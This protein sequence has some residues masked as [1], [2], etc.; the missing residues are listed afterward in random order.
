MI[1]FQGL[2]DNAIVPKPLEEYYEQVSDTVDDVR[3]FYRLFEIPGLGHCGGGRSGLPIHLFDDLK[4][5]VENGI[6]PESS[7]VTITNLEGR[8]EERIICPYPEKPEL[9][10][11]CGDSGN[12]DCWLCV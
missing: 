1:A 8:T 4:A 12:R 10:Q 11:D 5:W 6:V 9:D 2:A 3:S 7:P